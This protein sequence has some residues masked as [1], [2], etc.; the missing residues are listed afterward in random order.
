[1]IFVKSPL[2]EGIKPRDLTWID[3]QFRQLPGIAAPANRPRRIVITGFTRFGFWAKAKV[4]QWDYFPGFTQRMAEKGVDCF[5]VW[6]EDGLDRHAVDKNAAIIHLFNEELPFPY[7]Q[8]VAAA[9]RRAGFVFCTRRAGS[10]ISNKRTANKYLSANGIQ[11]PRMIDEASPEAIVFSNSEIGSGKA[12]RVL[13]PGDAVDPTRYNTEYI[14]T[15][16]EF[17]GSKYFTMFRIQA[18]G[19]QVLHAYVRARHTR[20]RSPS[21]HSKDTPADHQLIEYL[22][23]RLIR[24]REAGIASFA[25][26]M[27]IL[28][29]P[30]SYAHDMIVCNKTDRMYMVESGFKFND[31]P[32]AEYLRSVADRTPCNRIF[33]DG[34]YPMRAADLFLQEW[35]KA[36]DYGQPDPSLTLETSFEGIVPQRAACA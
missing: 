26:A 28:L 19:T 15:R 5:F 12:T 14:D 13:A 20:E 21:V 3:N 9:E 34:T 24:S 36:A 29:G 22:H 23:E 4:Y 2:S 30:G 35:E 16:I 6:D 25:S 32:Y 11:M 27:G 10:I 31:S 17:Q 33:Y 18:V 1:M 8:R 7:T